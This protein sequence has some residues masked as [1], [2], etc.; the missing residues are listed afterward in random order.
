MEIRMRRSLIAVLAL[1][2]GLSSPAM[3][4]A[5]TA[6]AKSVCERLNDAVELS[7]KVIAQEEA[8]SSSDNSAPRATL[9]AIKINNQLLVVSMNLQ[10]MRDNGCPSKKEPYNQSRYVLPAMTCQTDILKLQLG[11]EVAKMPGLSLPASCDFET[12]KPI[13]QE[14]PKP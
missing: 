12:W 5:D 6:P 9:S 8:R 4:F 1:C 3:S 14:P 13:G 11:Q 7:F 10:L 2:A